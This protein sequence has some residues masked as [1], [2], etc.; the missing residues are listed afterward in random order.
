MDL[1]FARSPNVLFAAYVRRV[2]R[3]SPGF[4]RVGFEGDD[5]ARLVPRGLD[6]R[7]KLLLPVGAVPEGLGES[8]LP[9]TE[10]RRRWRALPRERR[11]ALRSYTVG[12]A[13]PDAAELDIDFYVHARPGPGSAWA[14]RAQPGDVLMISAPDRRRE[15]GRHG[16]QW[17]PGVA[18]RVLLA[19]DETA[20]PA[21]RGI[22]RALGRDVS[23]S[24]I[25]EAH[26][27]ED[28]AWVRDEVV[29]G[30]GV[31]CPRGERQP[32]GESLREGVAAWAGREGGRA[33]DEGDGFYAWCA[34][35]SARVAQVRDTLVAV[36][37][38]AGRVHVQGYWNDRDRP[39][40]L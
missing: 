16:V 5:L 28:A 35:E 2:T 24:V 32:G 25:V 27:P 23:A 20:Y 36:G 30:A 6:Q 40:H 18:R 14:L 7:M 10:W 1:T 21:I 33:G 13:R 31:V 3:I 22:L 9:E 8:F 17:N 38:D 29:A 12:E 39:S 19:G 11:P 37:V 34:T 4:V 15:D 26:D